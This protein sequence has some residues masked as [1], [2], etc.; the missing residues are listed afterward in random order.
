SG[1]G[2]V[3]DLEFAGGE[4]RDQRRRA[5][6]ARGLERVGRAEML[7]E[8]LLFH[9]QRAPVADRHDPGH[10][11]LDR[12]GAGGRGDDGQ[13]DREQSAKDELRNTHDILPWF[14]NTREILSSYARKP[15]RLT[16]LSAGARRHGQT[17]ARASLLG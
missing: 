8:V 2:E 3:G 13:R 4:R 9:E 1:E 15:E 12:L 17:W 11:D 16:S 14:P 5:G 6:K 7:G 10:A